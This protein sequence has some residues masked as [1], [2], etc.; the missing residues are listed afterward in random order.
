[1]NDPEGALEQFLKSVALDPGFSVGRLNAG[2]QLARAGRFEEALPHLEAARRSASVRRRETYHVDHGGVLLALGRF[3][4]AARI[5]REGLQAHP[6]SQAM[7]FN[8]ELALARGADEHARK[9]WALCLDGRREDGLRELD[10]ALRAA[11]RHAD[12]RHYVAVVRRQAH[13]RFQAG[14]EDP[15]EL[16]ILASALALEGDWDEAR[17]VAQVALKVAQASGDAARA[18]VLEARLKLYERS[19]AFEAPAQGAE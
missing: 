19:V 16:A 10:L 6:E 7:R 13:E 9:G 1:M 12:A 3:G 14:A 17:A 4:E 8:L 5:L 2:N 11:P 15:Q 18:A